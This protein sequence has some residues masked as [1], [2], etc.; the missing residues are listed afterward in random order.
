MFTWSRSACVLSA[1][2][3]AGGLAACGTS[4]GEGGAAGSLEVE[5]GGD[6]ASSVTDAAGSL[7]VAD[8]GDAALPVTDAG[9][10]GDPGD[11]TPTPTDAGDLPDR[12]LAPT[13]GSVACGNVNG[14][15]PASGCQQTCDV[16]TSTCCLQTGDT[17]AGGSL[18]LL[19]T[20]AACPA[21]EHVALHCDHAANCAAGEV[22]CRAP[23]GDSACATSCAVTEMQLC[24]THSEC[25]NGEPCTFQGCPG[26]RPVEACGKNPACIY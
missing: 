25:L 3:V 20:T 26:F 12:G 22:C 17:D 10:S 16:H 14:R 7:E 8:G 4:S 2:I 6:A 23:N 15:C 9:A 18:C 13:P 24:R 19:G 11:A 21:Y 1:M 5:D